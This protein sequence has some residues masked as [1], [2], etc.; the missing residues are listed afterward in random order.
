MLIAGVKTKKNYLQTV[1]IVAWA[2]TTAMAAP[3]SW[4]CPE[5]RTHDVEDHVEDHGEDHGEVHGEDHDEDY[6]EDHDE[7]LW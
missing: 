7:E 4:V 3:I 2:R 5:Q 1:A 6:G